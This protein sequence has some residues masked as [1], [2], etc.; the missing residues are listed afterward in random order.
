[1]S[2]KHQPKVVANAIREAILKRFQGDACSIPAGYRNGQG[3]VMT[4]ADGTKYFVS[5]LPY[6][7]A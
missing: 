7:G 6:E 2:H 1:M 3:F 4:T 5:V